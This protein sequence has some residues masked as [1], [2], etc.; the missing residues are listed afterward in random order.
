MI[1]FLLVFISLGYGALILWFTDG[2]RHQSVVDI[3]NTTLPEVTIIVSAHNEEDNLPHLIPALVNQNYPHELLKLIIINDCS[4][5]KTAQILQNFAK[6]IN[7][8]TI[9]TIDETAKG[10][11]SKLLG[12]KTIKGLRNLRFICRRSK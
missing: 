8:L 6:E 7:N 12:V 1:Y 9:I 3:T 2:I 11:R 4:T 5:D 10:W